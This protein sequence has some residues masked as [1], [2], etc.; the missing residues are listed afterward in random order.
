[1]SVCSIAAT[2]FLNF[3]LVTIVLLNHGK[4]AIVNAHITCC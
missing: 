1:M 4:H 3:F 2:R